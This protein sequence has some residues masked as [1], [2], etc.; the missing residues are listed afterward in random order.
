MNRRA[1]IINVNMED[2]PPN[3]ENL[4]LLGLYHCNSNKAQKVYASHG[5]TYKKGY[6]THLNNV[7][8]QMKSKGGEVITIQADSHDA[9]VAAV[10]KELQRDFIMPG[11]ISVNMQNSNLQKLDADI[12]RILDNTY[13]EDIIFIAS[14]SENER[15][16]EPVL[17]C[18]KVLPIKDMGE[19]ELLSDLAYTIAKIMHLELPKSG[20]SII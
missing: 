8:K 3:M 6:E 5:F 14:L 13:D 4:G 11:I 9:A 15:K 7:L 1:I 19:I 2:I 20:K 18:S 12:M 17:M 10:V 16:S